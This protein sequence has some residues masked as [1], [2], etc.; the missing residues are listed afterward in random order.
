MSK[1]NL[2]DGVKVGVTDASSAWSGSND[3][4]FIHLISSFL[5]SS[6]A[7]SLTPY[8]FIITATSFSPSPTRPTNGSTATSGS[9]G[10]LYITSSSREIAS[11]AVHLTS[12]KFIG[13]I[14][15]STYT[16]STPDIEAE[17]SG[18]VS[19][20]FATKELEWMARIK[21]LH[22]S[23]FDSDII[24]SILLN[25]SRTPLDPTVPPPGSKSINT[26]LEE[27]RAQLARV[28]PRQALTEL[29]AV[30]KFATGGN[31]SGR[32]RGIDV[33][34][35]LVDIRPQAQRDEF[36]VIPGALIIERNVL[37]W[38][39]DPRSEARLPV[40]DRYD[41]R[42]IVH[43]QEGYTSSLA[44]HSL[45]QLGL[46]NATDI[47]GGFKAWKDAGLPVEVKVMKERSIASAAG[48]MV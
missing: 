40:A 41:L 19:L 15:S 42:V 37:E 18:N 2:V 46:L 20:G 4:P 43:C 6:F 32:A 38:R 44:A 8:L 31:N 14:T 3:I 9:D 47:I 13:R 28:T 26:I 36:G 30:G 39:F 29:R 10:L 34:T 1:S 24:H 11:R 45:Q 21:E 33:P 17:K 35:V 5:N 23:S 48:S 22:F 7:L 25:A 12:A 27:A 16:F